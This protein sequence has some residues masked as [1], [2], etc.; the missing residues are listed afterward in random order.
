MASEQTVNRVSSWMFFLGLLL[1][2]M[3]LY[4]FIR[5]LHVSIRSV[6]YPINGVLP[7][8]IITPEVSY[9]SAH[10]SD[11]NPDFRIYTDT[12]GMP[13]Q[14][15]EAELEQSAKISGRCVQGFEEDRAKQKQHDKNQ[16]AFLVFTGLG[17][18]F[19]RRF[20]D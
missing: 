9:N 15:T 17:L 12:S 10:E 6:P 1:F 20:L 16:S 7:A 11:C 8:T 14:P 19:A 3:G 5:I 18:I 2:L 13:R 4:G